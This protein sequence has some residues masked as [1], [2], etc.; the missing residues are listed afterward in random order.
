MRKTLSKDEGERKM[1]RGTL[2]R[3]GKK[4]NYKGYADETLLIRN[5]VDIE[6][7]SV[8]ADHLWFSYTKGFRDASICVG[9]VLEFLARVRKYSKGYRNPRYAIDQTTTDYKLSHPT[10]IRVIK[11]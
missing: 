3:I 6:T 4:I 7:G 10:R 1:F 11:G 9:D 2:T 8:V 5:I